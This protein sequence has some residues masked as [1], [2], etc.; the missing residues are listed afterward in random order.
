MTKFFDE[1]LQQKAVSPSAST[2]LSKESRINDSPLPTIAPTDYL[3]LLNVNV[4]S[5]S[6]GLEERKA[7][8][9]TQGS[10]VFHP[11]SPSRT[12][13]Q[14]TTTLETSRRDAFQ[15]LTLRS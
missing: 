1:K 11:G 8:T 5:N 3:R 13:L 7:F 2:S 14:Q 6:K 4:V 12:D 9:L 15:A 10:S